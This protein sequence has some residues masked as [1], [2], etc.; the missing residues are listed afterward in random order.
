MKTEKSKDTVEFICDDFE[1]ALIFFKHCIHAHWE[2]IGDVK[3]TL[4][5]DGDIIV[6]DVRDVIVMYQLI[7]GW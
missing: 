2:I 4:Y 3:I 5:R 1:K 6:N 7:K